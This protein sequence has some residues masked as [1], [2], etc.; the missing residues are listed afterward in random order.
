MRDMRFRLQLLGFVFLAV[1]A[2]AVN[3]AAQYG[4]ANI[5]GTVTDVSGAV[6]PGAKV[7]VSEA[8]KGFTRNLVTDST[9]TYAI[10]NVPIGTYTVSFEA[11]GFQKVVQTDITLSTGQTQ[12]VDAT[13]KVGAVTQQVT[14]QGNLPHVQTET[15]AISNV[16]TGQE[17]SQL[18]I[19]GRNFVRLALTVPGAVPDNG[20]ITSTVGV[21]ANN[22]I[23]FN[24]SRMQYNNWTVDGAPNTDEGSASTFNTYPNL[25][26]IAEFRISTSNY[27][28]EYGHHSGAQ[29]DVVTKSGTRQF[30]GSVS[31]Y[32]RNDV[33]DAQNFFTNRYSGGVPPKRAPL[34]QNEYGFT[35][36]GPFF[37]PGIYN[38]AKNKTFFFY[39]ED[40][41]KIR[42]SSVWSLDTLSALERKGD[43]S[44]CDKAGTGVGNDAAYNATVAKGCV[45]PVVNGV[46][47]DNIL[48]VPGIDQQ[49]VTNAQ[50]LVSAYFPNSNVP[51]NPI[52]WFGT[53]PN[54]TNWR[55]D[56]IR[57]DQNIGD[58]TRMFVRFTHDAWN[59]TVNPTLWQWGTGSMYDTVQTGFVA[60]GKSA[61]L[62]LTNTFSPTLMNEFIAGYT[63]DWI[64]LTNLPGGSSTGITR[65][66]N[67]NMAH[68]FPAN[69]GNPLLPAIAV[70]GGTTQCIFESAYNGNPWTN[71]NPIVDLQDN[72]T[73]VHGNHILKFG[74]YFEDYRKNETFGSAVQGE[75]DFWSGQPGSSGNALGDM[76]LGQLSDYLEGTQTNT[77]GVPIGGFSK[78]H[79]L[80]HDFEP[81]VED[82]W[83]VNSKLT[84][85]LGLRYYLFT[86]IHDITNPTVDSGF[87]PQLYNI[88]NEAQYNSSGNLIQG[89]GALPVAYGN[90]LVQCGSGGIP[91]GCQ[92]NTYNNWAP[93]FGF[94]Y[95][96]DP[97]TSIR[98]GYGIFYEIGNGNEAESEGGEGNPPHELGLTAYNLAGTPGATAVAA[99]SYPNGQ[100]V[101]G[102]I[103]TNGQYS[104]PIPPAGYT[105]WPYSQKW[106]SEQQFNLSVEHQFANDNLF[107]LA[108]VGM[109]GHHLALGT[110]FNNIPLGMGTVNVPQL[111]GANQYCDASGNCDVQNYLINQ[112][113]TGLFFDPYRGYAGMTMKADI[114][115]SNYNSLQASFRHTFG[116]G[117][118]TQIAY[119][120]SHNLDNASSTYTSNTRSVDP[121]N[122]E[123]WYATSDLNRAQVFT[124][125]YI[126]NLPFFK[127]SNSAVVRQALGGW[128][129]SG[130]TTLMTGQP[131]SFQCGVTGYSTGVGGGVQC[132]QIGSLNIN[133][134]VYNDPTYGPT[135]SWFNPGAIAQPSLSQFYAN[136]QS[137]MFG[138]GGRNTLT[139]P[140]DSSTD[141]ALMKNWKVSKLGEGGLI[142]FRWETFNT[143]NHVNWTG[144]NIGCSGVDTF[145]EAC[146]NPTNDMGTNA[147]GEVNGA[148]DPR[149]MQFGLEVKW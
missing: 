101:L 99:S 36:G 13:L 135:V 18:E 98:G 44:E 134:T 127:N 94:A 23:S 24:G 33:L 7:T 9:G 117:L 3:A 96:L 67:F 12:R 46:T 113:G 142:Q 74:A 47:Y 38:T 123:R 49:S 6:I 120:W 14:V 34:K 41:R 53:A 81:Y 48:D 55:E 29:I 114:A 91:A 56:Q 79:W 87:L 136:G 57:V 85:N 78:G 21:L 104:A 149:I 63:E 64:T 129:V 26:S 88:A 8:S 39:S 80:D 60:P 110:P 116:H 54:A 62:N 35:V 111:A 19:N 97:N 52:G 138:Y 146:N 71:S 139:G 148:R 84:L 45:L 115:N 108:Y 109:L 124:A 125:S 43:F 68:F 66:S 147:N 86:H 73:W 15:A 145:G 103:Y 25:D 27:G 128:E 42:G 140:G 137:G 11:K 119:T 82:D 2:L 144:F 143:F 132:N 20:L 17:I 76:F 130:I 122:N 93:R 106:P 75:A 22:S 58:K 77:S 90:G 95:R 61:V 100:Q 121:Y 32:L 131:V 4:V 5:V 28:A 133:K 16:V 107:S 37:I 126:Y 102:P 83:H 89:T 31:E 92:T 70:C 112:A 141:L 50:D 105:L 72:L 51:G 10:N 69:A 1:F 118:T 59:T 40:W 65:P 30:H